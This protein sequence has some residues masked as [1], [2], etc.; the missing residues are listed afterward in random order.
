MNLE[1]LRIDRSRLKSRSRRRWPG[2]VIALGV[3]A[4]ALFLVRVPLVRLYER[5]SLPEVEALIVMRTDPAVAGAVRGKAANGYIVAARRAALSADFAG[6]IVQMNVREGS[7]VKTGDVVARLYSEELE[8]ALRSAAARAEAARQRASQAAAE[9]RTTKTQVLQ[10]ESLIE[11]ARATIDAATA[12]LD[13]NRAELERVRKLV[14]D[15]VS[16]KSDLDDAQAAYDVAEADVRAAR[17]NVDSAEQDLAV[18]GNR[19]QVAEIAVAVSGAQVESATADQEQA[20]AALEKT[21]IRAPFDGVV[22]LKDAEVGEVVSPFSQGGSNAR[23]SV[24]TMVDFA[25]LEVQAN[26]PETSLDAVL[27]GAPAQIFVDAWPDRPYAGRVD[28]IWPT[29]DRQKG[30]IEVRV[31]FDA[32]DERLRPE[33]GVRVVFLPAGEAAPTSNEPTVARIL[34]PE[35]A[36]T[37]RGD[38]AAVFVLEGDVARLRSIETG[39]R[40]GGRVEVTRGLTEGERILS[41]PPADLVDGDRIRVKE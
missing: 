11:A 39:A 3:V 7:V 27:V 38:G 18:G 32:P 4:A 1:G 24:V 34:L 16:Q 20:R 9:H 19:V 22:V 26:V 21:K 30:T 29:A 36:V 12:R 23:G 33:L 28:R 37:N 5:V 40:A 15:G 6:R 8:A 25:S 41:A 31:V 17:A 14:A 35:G 10:L 2:R 13:Q